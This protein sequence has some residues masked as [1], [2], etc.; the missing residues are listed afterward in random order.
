MDLVVYKSAQYIG[1]RRKKDMGDRIYGRVHKIYIEKNA[2]L[3]AYYEAKND[4]LT[5]LTNKNYTQKYLN[6]FNDPH[7]QAK[8][9]TLSLE[10]ST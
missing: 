7:K 6:D 1:K 8:S 3:K 5:G 9:T 4:M 2:R 10:A